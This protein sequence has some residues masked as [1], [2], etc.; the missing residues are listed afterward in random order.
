MSSC[1]SRLTNAVRKFFIVYVARELRL[2]FPTASATAMTIRSM[3]QAVTGEAIAKMKMKGLSIAFGAA[4][5]VRVVSQYCLGIMW[6]W[7]FFTWFY[8]WGNYNNKAINVESWGWFLEFTPAFIG[9]GMLVGLNVSIS[10]LMGSV[11]AW[12]I[13]GPTLVAKNIAFGINLGEGDPKWDGYMSY[14]SL[15]LKAANKT[16]PSPRYWLLWP[17]VL[18][19]IVVSFTELALQWKILWFAFKALYRGIAAGIYAMGRAAGKE[20]KF[21]GKISAQR[22]ED[23][24]EDSASEDEQVKM[25]MWAPGLLLTIICIC[26]VL[27]VQHNM[28]VGM[29]LLSIFLAFFFSFVAIQCTGVTDITPLTAASKASQ[30]ILGG[31][32]KGE[33]W[34]VTHAQ[35]LNLLGGA[36]CN[37]GANQSTDLVCDFRTGFLLRTP[38]KLQWFAQG[39]GTVVAVFL[40]PA[41]FQL[42][43]TAYPCIIDA[44]AE[45]CV[46]AIPSVS[47][48]RATAVAVTDPTFP[49]PPSSGY[50]A[51]AFSIF[52]S[53]MVLIRHYVWVGRLEWVKTYHPNMM[54]IGLAFVLAQ[55]QY[56]TAMTIGSAF[57]YVWQRKRPESFDVYG[58]AIA[59]GLIA[60]EG[61]GGVIN[62]VFQI[63]GISGSVYG[64]QVACPMSCE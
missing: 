59:A 49:I 9:S 30:I 20:L 21:F 14:A 3:H 27:G 31:A 24:V 2:I 50:F 38:P 6:D 60:G 51:I 32:T 22:E 40:A 10:F 42:F 41:M 29:S 13:I 53:I 61:I 11:I 58:Y 34:D 33:H 16:H 52:G 25:W 39:L 35:R 18:L 48:W 28:P 12:G 23:L 64:T 36:M 62:A 44:N 26:V 37:M 7:H 17:G 47:A 4:L 43:A 19:M 5:I 57:A 54:C 1:S 56:G 63:A 45:T 8:I 55:T 46:F 15:S